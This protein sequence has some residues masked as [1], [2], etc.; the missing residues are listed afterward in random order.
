MR[1]TKS[2]L[3]FLFL[4]LRLLTVIPS[5]AFLGLR[6]IIWEE[7]CKIIISNG[8]AKSKY[9][10]RL[11]TCIHLYYF[12][13]YYCKVI[14]LYNTNLLSYR[15]RKSGSWVNWVSYAQG[16]S[17]LKSKHWQGA[18]ISSEAFEVLFQAHTTFGRIQFLS[19]GTKIPDV[20]IVVSCLCMCVWG[21]DYISLRP[22][23]ISSHPD[24][25]ITRQFVC[26]FF[27]SQQENLILASNC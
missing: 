22:P 1:S 5:A 9:P 3:L 21:G 20:L 2:L 26:F 18:V 16:L 15:S 12:I 13:T 11:G 7:Q 8:H 25:S 6:D 19:Y 10:F 14:D 24:L 23:A 4:A 17:K 27:Q